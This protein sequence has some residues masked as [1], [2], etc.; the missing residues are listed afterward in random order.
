MTRK[1]KHYQDKFGKTNYHRALDDIDEAG[2]NA[3][4]ELDKAINLNNEILEL[5]EII[6]RS[7]SRTSHFPEKSPTIPKAMPR[8]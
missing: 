3:N 2:E 6:T 5:L 1:K 8:T 4:I 7:L